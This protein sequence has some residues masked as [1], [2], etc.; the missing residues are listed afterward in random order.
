[1]NKIFEFLNLVNWVVLVLVCGVSVWKGFQNGVGLLG[2]QRSRIL[3]LHMDSNFESNS[4]LFEE[5][6]VLCE[7]GP[8]LFVTWYRKV[9]KEIRKFRKEFL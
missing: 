7:G 9:R 3:C 2:F 1:M 6:F 8:W 5:V 4:K